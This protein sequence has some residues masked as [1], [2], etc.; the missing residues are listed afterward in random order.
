LES[1]YVAHGASEA[2]ALERAGAMPLSEA[3]H[4]LDALI[5]RAQDGGPKRKW[6]DAMNADAPDHD[7]A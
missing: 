1:E 2:D 4:V 5:A 7:H 3:K 6:W